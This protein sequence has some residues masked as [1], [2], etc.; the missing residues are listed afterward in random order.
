M[1]G[2]GGAGRGI[3]GVAAGEFRR[4]DFGKGSS[5]GGSLRVTSARGHQT[6]HRSSPPPTVPLPTRIKSARNGARRRRR[7]PDRYS[8]PGPPSNPEKLTP[9]VR[10]S[11]DRLPTDNTSVHSG[12]Q[13]PGASVVPQP[14]V[15][16]PRSG[17][18]QRQ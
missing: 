16:T 9:D 1:D 6:A 4:D 17:E 15:G 3:C 18:L 8:P 12:R 7:R 11:G 10:Y 14:S 13:Q 5:C 2:R